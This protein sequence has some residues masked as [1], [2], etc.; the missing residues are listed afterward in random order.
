M[1]EVQDGKMMN[2]V[3]S[4][5]KE[6]EIMSM[7][8]FLAF[9]L[10]LCMLLPLAACGEKKTEPEPAPQPT[11][12]STPAEPA[13]PNEPAQPAEPGTTEPA[14]V[15][16]K[17]YLPL[18]QPGEDNKIRFGLAINANCTDYDN[19][20]LT[21]WIEE[22]TG[23]DLEF[24]LYSG[25]SS[26]IVTQISL[27]IAANEKL[28][29]I[30]YGIDLSFAACNEYGQSEYFV[31]L[32][33]YFD[34]PDLSY[35]LRKTF[36]ENYGEDG[37]KKMDALLTYATD[38][39][40][41]NIYCFPSSSTNSNDD[42]FLQLMINK[43]WLEK[44]NL[45]APH[46]VQELYDVLVAFRDKDPNGNGKKDEIP[47]LGRPGN[48][49]GDI[50]QALINAYIYCNDTNYYNIDKGVV[51][52]PYGSDEYRQAL[53]F[54][55]KLV[56]E[57]LLSPLAWTLSK[58]EMTGLLNPKDG[59][60]TVGVS[61][62]HPTIVFPE[63]EDG[64]YHYIPLAPFA[65]ATGKGGY[66]P[67]FTIK[68][69]RSTFISTDAK[70]PELAFKL[71]C[72]LSTREC[73]TRARYGECGVDWVYAQPGELDSNG[74][75]AYFRLL[76][77]NIFTDANNQCWHIRHAIIDEYATTQVFD[78]VSDYAK[79][80]AA[81]IAE[82]FAIYDEMPQAEEVYELINYTQ[83][84][85]D[86]RNE[87]SSDLT[88]YIKK[89]RSNFCTGVTDPADDAAWKTDL[90]DLNKLKVDQYVSIAQGAY[91]RNRK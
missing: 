84:E 62:G 2:F 41:G 9:L 6:K 77:E 33:D 15:E 48:Y 5:E 87:I 28:P 57:G 16:E 65:D 88:S 13:S 55:K 12:P 43:D 44:L 52:V 32:K 70:N 26:D 35:W 50:I 23:I 38:K 3:N 37:E 85:T 56:D 31:N 59:V 78:P 10:V 86:A 49:R 79:T 40:T 71:L 74:N 51:S 4:A 39:A 81:Y 69:G 17:S 60:Y 7:K 82:Q 47:M 25:T 63:G 34:D 45:K 42:M 75:Q 20:K 22:Q 73:D 46:T 61:G 83:E 58:N 21:Q 11:E 1:I 68:A 91:D 64:L 54:I 27:A 24:V 89:A 36:E 90:D 8:R 72:F 66:A 29:D 14:P 53:I 30:L 67:M 76:H 18:V 19:N 80:R